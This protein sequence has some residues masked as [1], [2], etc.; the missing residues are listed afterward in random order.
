MSVANKKNID[1][2]C[3]SALLIYY[4]KVVK[5]TG[6]VNNINKNSSKGASHGLLIQKVLVV[7]C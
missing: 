6:S 7:D 2:M 1:G 4:K 3:I 5:E